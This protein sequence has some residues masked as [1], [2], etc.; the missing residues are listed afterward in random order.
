[1]TLKSDPWGLILGAFGPQD[2]PKSFP[3]ALHGAPE[4][5]FE[6]SFGAP[7]FHSVFCRFLGAPQAPGGVVG[8]R[9]DETSGLVGKHH[10]GTHNSEIPMGK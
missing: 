3:G 8:S 9:E 4:S 6:P 2:G 7:Y 10:F 1:M 5:A